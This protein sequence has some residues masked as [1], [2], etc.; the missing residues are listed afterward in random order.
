VILLLSGTSDSRRLAAGLA[1]RGLPAT[2]SLAG[3]TRDP[4]PLPLP[5]RT[6]GFGGAEGFARFLD[7][8]GVRAV[9][10]ATHPFAAR[11]T[12]R[13]VAVCASRT[14]PLLRLERPGWTPAPGDRWTFVADQAEAA[15]LIP[16]DA[17]VFLA[18]GRQSLP[19]WAGLRARRVHVRVIDLPLGRF[20]FPGGFVVG[21]PPFD[22]ASESGLLRDL[23]ITHLVVKD[24]GA[25]EARAKLDAAR[26]LGLPVV[27]LR[28]PPRP[29]GLRVAETVEEALAWAE[30]VALSF[31][32]P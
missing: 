22:R 31:P 16:P 8:H 9:I 32:P 20:P 6:G 17:V 3:A 15:A 18:T 5:T 7:S 29:P 28:R 23:G 12:A 11:I 25:A 14:L 2:A 19:G 13:T 21:R 4:A 27:V 24:S 30:Q 10:D 1:E 26:D